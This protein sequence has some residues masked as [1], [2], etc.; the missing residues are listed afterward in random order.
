MHWLALAN[1]VL[2]SSPTFRSTLSSPPLG[3]RFGSPL[4]FFCRVEED[5]SVSAD[6]PAARWMGRSVRTPINTGGG[7]CRWLAR[8]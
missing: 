4:V 7:S 8:N 5:T 6:H 2:N 1:G 3:D